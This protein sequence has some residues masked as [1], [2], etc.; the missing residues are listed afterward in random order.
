MYKDR[1]EK[2]PNLIYPPL[3]G[4]WESVCHQSGKA[5]EAMWDYPKVIKAFE[6][7]FILFSFIPISLHRIRNS[8]SRARPNGLVD[9]PIEK[10]FFDLYSYI[11]LNKNI[12]ECIVPTFRFFYPEHKGSLEGMHSFNNFR[13]WVNNKSQDEEL[14]ELIISLTPDFNKVKSIRD[15]FIH[16]FVP[17]LDLDRLTL[18]SEFILWVIGQ[19]TYHQYNSLEECLVNV[20]HL[21]LNSM[22]RIEDIF[23][24]RAKLLFDDFDSPEWTGHIES[25]YGKDFKFY[26]DRFSAL[27]VELFGASNIGG[28]LKPKLEN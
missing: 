3:F 24:E 15:N 23:I 21:I 9:I 17:G 22:T 26:F 16:P 7:Y 20:L 5:I 6:E 12:F 27:P 2:T 10:L 11:I 14:R 13:K 8:I 25:E 19:K 1:F 28:S 4:I 18:N